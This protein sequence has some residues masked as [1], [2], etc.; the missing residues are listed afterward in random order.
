MRIAYISYEHPLGISGGGIGTYIGQISR[1]M[2]L[3]G[4]DVEVFSG[5]LAA[6]ST[7]TVD[8]YILNLITADSMAMFREAVVPVFSAKHEVQAF[9]LIESPEYGADALEIKKKYRD[10]PLTVKLHTPSFLINEL[11]DYHSRMIDRF[12]FIAGGL[13]KGKIAKAY[14]R[15]NQDKD[16]EYELFKLAESV[17]S[18]SQSLAKLIS[19]KWNDHK[20]IAVI[21]Y[22]FDC[23]RELLEIPVKPV[24]SRP[25]KITYIGRLEK[26]KGIF[27]LMKAIPFLLKLFP[28]TLFSF[29]GK[30]LPSP[31][32]GDDMAAYLTGKLKIYSQ[33]LKLSGFQPYSKLPVILADTDICIFPSL[34]ENFPNVCLEAMA[35]GRVVI[36]TDN[37]G[38]ADMIQNGVSGILIPPDSS[39]AIIKAVK[40]LAEAP[41]KITA[42]GNAARQRIIGH[43]NG[44]R[45]GEITESHYRHTIAIS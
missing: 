22:P 7:F 42:I 43:Y 27:V 18:P 26:R 38:M 10:L 29:V 1:L 15:Y 17:T 23:R 4:H 6:P 24:V 44:R 21:P 20:A 25:L 13:R 3:M 32:R 2:A 33:N 14:W 8:G 36:G 41:E 39:K 34:W 11:N 9:E 45:I 37:G 30:A 28:G 35:A 12:R 31:R 16:K 40:E 19:K 5:T